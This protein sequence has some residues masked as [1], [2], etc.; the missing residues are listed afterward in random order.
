MTVV[1]IITQPAPSVKIQVNGNYKVTA[2]PPV[3]SKMTASGLFPQ[4][5]LSAYQIAVQ[6]GFVGTEA[7]WLLSLK[8]SDGI[9]GPAGGSHVH[10]QA[11][12]AAVWLVNHNL[13]FFPNVTVVDSA[14][15]K[16]VGDVEYSDS[17][18]L[19]ISFSGAFSGKAYIS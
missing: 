16:V 3:A 11:V 19:I 2:V 1:K 10:T 9:A 4:I 13:G 5:G 7:A 17:N 12:P 6:N 14:E 15:S 18:N 8:G